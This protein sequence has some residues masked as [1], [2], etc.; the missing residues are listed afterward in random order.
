MNESSVLLANLTEEKIKLNDVSSFLVADLVINMLIVT[1]TIAVNACLIA[2]EIRVW[3]NRKRISQPK[4]L[5][6]FL[7][8]TD[9]LCSLLGI[10][11]KIILFFNTT[12]CL[13]ASTVFMY[14]FAVFCSHWFFFLSK[15]MVVL[16]AIERCISIRAPFLYIR[17]CTLKVFCIAELVLVIYALLFAI[18]SVYFEFSVFEKVVTEE[19]FSHFGC[20]ELF[21]TFEN[22]ILNNPQSFR[23][24]ITVHIDGFIV[25]QIVQDF[26]LVAILFLCNMLVISGLRDMQRRINVTR[27]EPSDHCNKEPDMMMSTGKEFSRLMLVIIVV[28]IIL[29]TPSAVCN[30]IDFN[31]LPNKKK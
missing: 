21:L 27:P 8:G 18:T 3:K 25:L 28:F 16:M 24:S 1:L 30:T 2:I 7:A 13:H 9:I 31:S 19:Q 17:R 14:K 29:I 22:S 11:P 23:G 26:T 5:I 4:M 12:P 20:H 6:L 15:L 10:F